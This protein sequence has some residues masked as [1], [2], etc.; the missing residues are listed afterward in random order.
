[1]CL[2]T[3]LGNDVHSPGTAA[4]FSGRRR[5]RR[6]TLEKSSALCTRVLEQSN[7]V[8]KPQRHADPQDHLVHFEFLDRPDDAVLASLEWLQKRLKYVEDL[9]QDSA[10]KHVDRVTFLEQTLSDS[11]EQHAQHAALPIEQRDENPAFLEQKPNS[12]EVAKLSQ[13]QAQVQEL[14][15]ATTIRRTDWGIEALVPILPFDGAVDNSGFVESYKQA[16]KLRLEFFDERAL[17]RPHF[18]DA[19]FAVG[20]PRMV[21]G[22][23][24]DLRGFRPSR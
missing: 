5:R 8:A 6:S 13:V 20:I 21:G 18:V 3:E 24:V 11:A 12:N 7:Q 14:A 19:C 9:L 4:S 23:L 17:A 2:G 1:M 16:V 15:A 22:A 10:D